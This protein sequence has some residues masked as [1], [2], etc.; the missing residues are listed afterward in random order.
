MEIRTN[1]DI[2]APVHKVWEVLMDFESHRNWNPFI[3]KIKGVAKKGEP[4]SIMTALPNG[5][6]F[7]FSPIVTTVEENK[8]FFWQGKVVLRGLFDA[9]HCFE[10]IPMKNNKTRLEHYESFSGLLLPFFKKMLNTH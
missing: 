8:K 2:N 7:S 1:I 6:V 5:K 3:T 9:E 4:L 10:L